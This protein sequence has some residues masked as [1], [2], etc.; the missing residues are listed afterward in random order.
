LIAVLVEKTDRLYGIF[1]DYVTL[2]EL[3]IEIH[4]PKEGTKSQA[5][6][7]H[8]IQVVIARN[9][10]ENLREEVRKGMVEKAEQGIYPSRPPMGY[11]NNKL[12]HTIEVDV[13]KAPIAPGE[14]RTPDLLVRRGISHYTPYNASQQGPVK[15]VRAASFFRLV[16]CRFGLRNF[17]RWQV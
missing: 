9:Y 13:E 15:S 1:G 4:L 11:R 14:S 10:I 8:G 12:E 16:T 7:V 3:R 17:P 6:L 5:K 2:E